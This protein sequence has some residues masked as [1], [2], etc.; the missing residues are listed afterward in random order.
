M[1]S[2]TPKETNPTSPSTSNTF[3]QSFT[4]PAHRWDRFGF[5]GSQTGSEEPYVPTTSSFSQQSEWPTFPLTTTPRR[6]SSSSLKMPK[7]SKDKAF[8]ATVTS[9]FLELS[10]SSQSH[11]HLQN[12]SETA[13]AHV[14]S[15]IA[16]STSYL[17]SQP[18]NDN[19]GYNHAAVAEKRYQFQWYSAYIKVIVGFFFNIFV[20]VKYMKISKIMTDILLF[21][22]FHE[23]FLT[24]H[25]GELLCRISFIESEKSS[26]LGKHFLFVSRESL[27]SQKE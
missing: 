20:C 23:T 21:E 25:T 24:L 27:I 1:F 10:Q 26:A 13:G 15:S 5:Y 4:P 22:L 14:I 6:I 16:V 7:T 17:G 18:M 19:L 3:P 8:A 12:S 11:K 2:Q 9:K